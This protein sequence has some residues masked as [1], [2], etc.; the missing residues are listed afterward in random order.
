M[1]PGPLLLVA[2]GIVLLGLLA[3]AHRASYWCPVRLPLR[4][5]GRTTAE[6]RPLP[7][8]PYE[9]EIEVRD[10]RVAGLAAERARRV[11]DWIYANQLPAGAPAWEIRTNAELQV[12]GDAREPAY[13]EIRL[14]T[15]RGR[16]RDAL[17]FLPFQRDSTSRRSFGLAGGG[18]LARGLGHFRPGGEGPFLAAVTPGPLAEEL[19]G[20]EPSFNI[21][22]ARQEWSRHWRRAVPMAVTAYL[23][24]ATG[25]AWWLL[26]RLGRRGRHSQARRGARE[27]D[28]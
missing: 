3:R 10:P 4:H 23:A 26:R 9:I 12:A 2:T 21:R 27:E 19:A 22:V 14:P 13:L 1:A 5:P 11:T 7:G 15:W 17:L 20:L 25:G 24:L 6:F 8:L 18:T 16:L 28:D